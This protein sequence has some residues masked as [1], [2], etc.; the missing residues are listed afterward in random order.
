MNLVYVVQPLQQHLHQLPLLLSVS[1]NNTLTRFRTLELVCEMKIVVVTVL[2]IMLLND[3]IF[4]SVAAVTP[5]EIPSL[6]TYLQQL[7]ENPINHLQIT[8]KSHQ[9]KTIHHKPV[10][11]TLLLITL[12]TLSLR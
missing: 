3:G 4:Q 11:I 7:R 5:R 8:I 9:I 2:K 12:I 10:N 6:K 1:I